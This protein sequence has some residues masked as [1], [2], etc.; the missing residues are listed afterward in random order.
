MNVLKSLFGKRPQALAPTAPADVVASLEQAAA[1]RPAEPADHYPPTFRPTLAPGVLSMPEIFDPAVQ[2]FR[3]GFRVGEP[4]FEDVD[5]ARRWETAVRWRLARRRAMEHVLRL[6]ST[7]PWA[8]RL[9]LRGSILMPA[10]VGSEARE[11]NDLDFVCDIATDEADVVGMLTDLAHLVVAEPTCAGDGDR[12]E[13]DG[14]DARIVAIWT[15]FRAPGRRAVFP[16]STDGLPGGIVQV[17]LVTGE[18][19]PAE[20]VLVDVPLAGGGTLPVRAANRELSLAWKLLWLATDLHPQGKDLYDATLLAERLLADGAPLTWSLLSAVMAA[21]DERDL[22]RMTIDSFGQG[23]DSEWD[24]FRTEYPWLDVS[25]DELQR[26]LR[27]ALAP[28]F[29]GRET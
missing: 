9:V 14:R 29:A 20:P 1:P 27:A 26:R 3:R 16:W 5:L 23:P 8:D 17:D 22:S 12:I 7:A 6:R 4:R 2:H 18:P 25:L 13:L 15:Y 11:P 28:T 21:S 19:R 24:H 10:W